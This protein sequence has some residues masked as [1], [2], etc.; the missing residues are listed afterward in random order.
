MGNRLKKGED[1]IFVHTAAKKL[2]TRFTSLAKRII[3][4]LN[5][6]KETEDK[7]LD[8][9]ERNQSASHICGT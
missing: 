8:D 9:M 1:Q 6:N 5:N 7:I 2:R 3:S 4:A